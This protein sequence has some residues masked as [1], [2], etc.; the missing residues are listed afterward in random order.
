MHSLD[1]IRAEY[2]R[3][4]KLLGIDT[5]HIELKI[6]QR[7]LRQLGCFRCPAGAG[8]GPL[9]ITISR[10]VMDSDKLFLDTIRHEYAHAAAYLLRPGER[11]GHDEFWKSICRRIGCRPKSRSEASYEVQL[12]R[13]Q[14][15]KYSVVCFGCGQQSYYLRRGKVVD[16]LLRGRGRALRCPRCGGSSFGLYTKKDFPT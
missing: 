13:R 9:S 8:E 2:A 5:S 4:D 6:S 12:S 7:A 14:Q 16:M 1:E 3:L 11:H 10:A 15:A